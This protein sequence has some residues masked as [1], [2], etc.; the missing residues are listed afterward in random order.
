MGVDGATP[1]ADAA[2]IAISSQAGVTQMSQLLV[3]YNEPSVQREVEARLP[4][5][6]YTASKFPIT[7][8]VHLHGC[9]DLLSQCPAECRGVRTW[10][11]CGEA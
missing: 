5:A 8:T 3:L 2:D 11:S 10:G 7:H 9:R 6:A 1:S 4:L